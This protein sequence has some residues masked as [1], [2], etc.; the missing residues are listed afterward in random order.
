MSG[1]ASDPV[2]LGELAGIPA[3]FEMGASFLGLLTVRLGEHGKDVIGLVAHV[4]HYVA[5]SAYPEAAIALLN[6]LQPV[7]GLTLPS[8]GRLDTAAIATREQIESQVARSEEAQHIVAQLE[9]QYERFMSERAL[10]SPAKIPT[11]DQIGA[12]VEEYLKGLDDSTDQ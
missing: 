4:P 9:D 7:S 5:D 2:L 12:E 3:S 6:Q 11:A 10:T 1:F 8:D